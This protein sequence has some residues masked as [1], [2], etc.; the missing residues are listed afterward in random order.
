MEGSAG[1]SL[2]IL[3]DSFQ[4]SKC[5]SS[6]SRCQPALPLQLL[7]EHREIIEVRLKNY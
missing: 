4:M 1:E 6:G 5:K 7:L 3:E 2:V